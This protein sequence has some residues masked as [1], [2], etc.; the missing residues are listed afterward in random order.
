[1]PVSARVLLLL[2]RHALDMH[3]VASPVM[4][5]GAQRCVRARACA[6]GERNVPLNKLRAKEKLQSREKFVT[7]VGFRPSSP[8]KKL[9][10]PGA[11]EGT[12]TT[13]EHLPDGTF[14]A[15]DEKPRKP[16]SGPKN[17]LTTVPKKGGFGVPGTTLGAYPEYKGE[18][19][20]EKERR[21]RAE[22][23][24]HAEAMGERKAFKSMAAPLA[25]LDTA[26]H[27]A[28]AV[29]AVYKRDDKC[30]PLRPDPL[31]GISKKALAE[32]RL[33]ERGYEK[34]FVPSHP[35]KSG[36]E[37]SFAPPPEAVPEPYDLKVLFKA[38]QPRRLAPAAEHMAGLPGSLGERA[39][40]K[41][42]SG[43]KGGLTR[44]I[45][46]ANISKATLARR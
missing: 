40:F 10:G 46:R 44:S 9:T 16:E 42:S 45:A 43:P 6:Q 30:L 41:P 18:P 31:A 17:F 21:Q 19:Y 37:G 23:L 28:S 8:A 15:R 29:S 25:T 11:V 32:K 34:A 12:F 35:P 22:R 20:G 33:A 1:M 5:I 27:S 13:V 38:M 14:P 3:P 4:W 24:V 7:P 36:I 2:L 26:E 39:S